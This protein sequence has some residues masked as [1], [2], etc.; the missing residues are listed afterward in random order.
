MSKT[1]RSVVRNQ[2][3]QKKEFSIRERHNERKNE[4]YYNSDIIAD[5]RH[6]NIHFK[7]CEGTYAETFDNMLAAGAISTRGLKADA[8]V[9]DELVF[10]VNTGYFDQGGGYGYAK[11]FF[12]EAYR[13]AVEVAGGEEY[14]LSAVMHADEKNIALSEQLGRDVFHY[15]LHIVYIPVVEKEIRWSKRC[16]DPALVGTVKEVIKQVSHSKKWPMEKKLDENGDVM[17]SKNGK[18]V[19]INS[20]SLLQDRYFEHMKEAGFIGF[21]R[22]ER[23]STAEH[24]SVLEYKTRQEAKRAAALTIE[25]EQKNE[26]AAALDAFITEKSE[27]SN[28]LDEKVQKKQGRLASL[29]KNIKLAKQAAAT[30]SEIDSMGKKTLFGKIELSQNDWK[31]VTG[32]A[33]GSIKSKDIAKNLLERYK[34]LQ[35]QANSL[36]SEITDLKT[37]LERYGEGIGITETMRYYQAQQ[38]APHRMAE[39]IAD[40]MRK[41]PEQEPHRHDRSHSKYREM[42]L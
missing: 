5:R 4:N 23:G 27:E 38:R 41:P 15:H 25:V 1:D 35:N 37:R 42:G 40:I 29:D 2:A 13:L 9:F 21:E 10:D 33:K 16:K 18:P 20:Y 34:N 8:K 3:Y 7:Q 32:L 14:V 12:A 11:A 26:V 39:I 28:V 30:I 17:L 31:K 24:L 22:G 36:L 19:L 6:L